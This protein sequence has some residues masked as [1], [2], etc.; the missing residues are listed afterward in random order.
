MMTFFCCLSPNYGVIAY[1][2]RNSIAGLCPHAFCYYEVTSPFSL[3]LP[4]VSFLHQI[5]IQFVSAWLPYYRT[6]NNSPIKETDFPSM[7]VYLLAA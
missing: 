2:F 6:C 5:P 4:S 3:L 1:L 7:T